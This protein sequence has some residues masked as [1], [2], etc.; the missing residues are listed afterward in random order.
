[1]T[2]ISTGVDD[3]FKQP[4]REIERGF[5]RRDGKYTFVHVSVDVMRGLLR[6]ARSLFRHSV[7]GWCDTICKSSS[8][9]A[10]FFAFLSMDE[11]FAAYI[12]RDWHDRDDSQRIGLVPGILVGLGG[13]ARL[14]ALGWR[15]GWENPGRAPWSLLAMRRNESTTSFMDVVTQPASTGTCS[16]KNG[17]EGISIEAAPSNVQRLG[18]ALPGLVNGVIKAVA[19]LAA[20][21][22]AGSLDV[23]AMIAAQMM[24]A[25]QGSSGGMGTRW[26]R[27]RPPRVFG[28]DRVLRPLVYKES[29]AS[30]LLARIES[31]RFAAFGAIDFFDLYGSGA[32][33]VTPMYLVCLPPEG[34][35]ARR[36]LWHVPVRDV[37]CSEIIA[38]SERAPMYS[39]E[40]A[41]E[42]MAGTEVPPALYDANHGTLLAITCLA[43]PANV[44][45]SHA[46]ECSYANHG[47]GSAEEFTAGRQVD[48]QDSAGSRSRSNG[49]GFGALQTYYVLCMTEGTATR[50]QRTLSSLVD[51]MQDHSGAFQPRA[52]AQRNPG[53]SGT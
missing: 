24:A 11:E 27:M 17:G 10:R 23:A 53:M 45:R 3:L 2:S 47:D 25:V 37:I 33:R 26:R 22:I 36:A 13:L 40:E 44:T 1:V 6:G 30:H 31:G 35:H 21:P 42:C 16:S 15:Q 28:Y 41:F 19:G 43:S 29:Q 14:P 4:V 18:A 7:L 12:S 52:T 46:V 5:F 9:G 8:S 34:R 51:Q 48:H 38:D 32:L 50:L 39:D 20:K 49:G